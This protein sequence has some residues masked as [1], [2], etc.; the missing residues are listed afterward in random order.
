VNPPLIDNRYMPTFP[1][2]CLAAQYSE[3]VYIKPRG[4]ERETHVDSD[5]RMGTK[6]MVIKSLPMD[7][8]NTIVF[9][10]RGTQ[11]FMDWAVN[12]RSAPVAPTGF[13]VGRLQ[14]R[15]LTSADLILG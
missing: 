5:W 12:L 6:A 3:R 1:L 2:L 7:D 15:D 10:I 4:Q 14:S 8:M 11:T 9:A 13:L